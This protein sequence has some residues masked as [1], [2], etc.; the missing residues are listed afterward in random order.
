MFDLDGFIERCRRA[1]LEPEPVESVR[2]LLQEVVSDRRSVA[3]ALPATRAELDVLYV[4]PDVNVMKVVWGPGMEFPPHDHLTWA[5]VGM[6]G[7]VERNRL[8]RLVDDR[9]TICGGFEIGE[10]DVG[11]LDADVIHAVANPRTRQFSAAIHVY[12]G[13]FT[14]LPRSNWLGDPPVRA[15]ASIEHTQAVF[16][17]A[18]ER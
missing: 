7:G 13:G 12:G 15:P 8:Y 1:V 10:G 2:A 11:V 18:N 9:P 5:C 14:E 16:E 6:Y 3:A 17:Q 4:G